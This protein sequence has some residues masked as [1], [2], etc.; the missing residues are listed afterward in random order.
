M[1]LD[2]KISVA[3]F[4]ETW[5][6]LSIPDQAISVPGYHLV[7]NDRVYKKGGGIAIYIREGISFK[8]VYSS[9]V[10]ASSVCKTECL[11]LEL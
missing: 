10:T 6:N 3:C 2:S 1:L 8:S 9:N 11:A 7:R 5:L 4:S